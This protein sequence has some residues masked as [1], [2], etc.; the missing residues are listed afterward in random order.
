[1]NNDNLNWANLYASLDR[2]LCQMHQRYAALQRELRETQEHAMRSAE[3]AIAMGNKAL[4]LL[5]K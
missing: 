2:E 5:K 1:M 3:H 4:E